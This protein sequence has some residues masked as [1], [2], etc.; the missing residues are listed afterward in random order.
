ME[1]F[2]ADCRGAGP[3]AAAL[4]P[5]SGRRD[6][7]WGISLL[8]WAVR[9][10]WGL[11]L[12]ELAEDEHGKPFFPEYPRCHF[13]L[14]HSGGFVLCGLDCAP[15]GVD[16]QLRRPLRP[17]TAEKLMPEGADL[18]FFQLWALRESY[19]KLDGRG[20]LRTAVFRR[21]TGGKILAP[22]AGVHCRLYDCIPG[23]AAAACSRA[24]MPPPELVRVPASAL[25]AGTGGGN[26]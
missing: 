8:A 5:R 2:Y 4:P 1:I 26:P 7:A 19:L 18:D 14:S 22:E 9:R 15:L 20:S 16:V 6:S 10:V 23:C 17:G 3:D 11:P 25:M 24:G 12:P 21:G 13:S